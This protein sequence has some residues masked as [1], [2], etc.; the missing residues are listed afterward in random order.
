[1]DCIRGRSGITG[2]VGASDTA[3]TR[4]ELTRTETRLDRLS[5]L[6]A[7]PLDVLVIGGGINGAGIIRDLALRCSGMPV[8]LGLVER[9]HFSS[10]TSGR[11]SQLIHG[12]LRYLKNM[13]FPLVSEA[14]AERG[15]LLR[16]A[17]H[18]V[19]A[20]PFLIPLRDWVSAA[21][22][23]TGLLLYDTL[24][25]AARIERFRHLSGDALKNLEPEMRTFRAGARFF[26]CQVNS[27]RLVLLNIREAES[28]GAM[29]LNYLSV[30]NLLKES[31]LWQAD[32]LD[33]LSGERFSVQAK[34]VVDATG[35]WTQEKNLRLVRGSHLIFPRLGNSEN[36]IAYFHGDGRVIFFIPWGR[37][38]ELTLV[39]TTDVD[40]LG[41]VDS[42]HI[43]D[44]EVSY[45]R[46]IA[47]LV[48]PE[49]RS[50]KPICSYSS[51]RPLVR[52]ESAS[53]TKTSREH[54]IWADERG[55]VHV[56]GGKYTTYRKMS[57]E[58]VDL[59]WPELAAKHGTA[60]TPILGNS[61]ERVGE[62]LGNANT[63]GAE[64]GIPEIDIRDIIHDY[65]V[66]TPDLLRM[67]PESARVP[68]LEAAQIA[69]AARHEWVQHLSDLI[70]ISTYWG[71]EK[72]WR[73]DMLLPYA[74]E[75]GSHL[76]W[77]EQ[78]VADEISRVL[79]A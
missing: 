66:E 16:T 2:A 9:A 15:I 73:S 58:T 53:A 18:L 64:H 3:L 5:A 13:E 77:Q 42:V 65:G 28:R 34:R 4:I 10:G 44:E 68:R 24:A 67:L 75:L 36:A 27:A 63:L 14:L 25:G 46:G 26:D 17:P 43:S 78:R 33:E 45:L 1:V 61:P 31:D 6:R 29:A 8:R 40:H 23:E 52:D 22:Y 50:S 12:G 56:S 74:Q 30:A 57:E 55:M 7:A 76:G 72:S 39:G 20:L 54:R 47:D 60:V 70:F 51:L 41:S 71:Y 79:N 49:S 59:A 21:F 37:R 32:L 19:T 69:F 62:L 11:N 48:F 38:R 35:A